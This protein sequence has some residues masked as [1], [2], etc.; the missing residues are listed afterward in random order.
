[1]LH[2]RRRGI[3]SPVVVTVL[4]GELSLA[5]SA[6]A[7]PAANLRDA[8]APARSGTSCG[9]LRYNAVVEQLAQIINRPTDTYLNQ[10]ATRVPIVDPLEGLKD[11][12]R[13]VDTK[14]YLPQGADKSESAAIKGALSPPPRVSALSPSHEF[15]I[16]YFPESK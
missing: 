10:A 15:D 9:P 16:D 1:M 13:G 12:G 3:A 2:G 6:L 7:D 4:A 5:S 8:L 14:A 11:V